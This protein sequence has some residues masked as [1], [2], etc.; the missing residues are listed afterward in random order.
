MP[1]SAGVGVSVPKRPP[2]RWLQQRVDA[3]EKDVDHLEQALLGDGIGAEEG[4]DSVGVGVKGMGGVID[5][6][7]QVDASAG[8]DLAKE[9]LL[10]EIDGKQEAIRT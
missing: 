6:A 4:G 1:A 7:G 2:L 3:L 5:V 8:G 9:G 10:Y